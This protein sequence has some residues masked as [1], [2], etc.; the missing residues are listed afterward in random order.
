MNLRGINQH[1]LAIRSGVSKTALSRFLSGSSDIRSDSLIK[2]MSALGTDLESH[3]KKEISKSISG[4][5]DQCVGED[6][7][8][9]LHG[10]DAISKKTLVDSVVSHGK[11]SKAAE[12]K[13]AIQRLKKYRDG[14]KTVRRLS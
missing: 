5:E 8:S 9:V 12:V 11:S 2:L 7:K 14:I 3:L 13:S 10:M 6:I 4:F 1:N